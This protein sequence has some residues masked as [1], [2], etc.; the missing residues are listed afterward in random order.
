MASF[1]L[2]EGEGEGMAN[3]SDYFFGKCFKILRREYIS[4]CLQ[5]SSAARNAVW[6]LIL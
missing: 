1:T 6:Y 2:E 5:I 3:E 4:R